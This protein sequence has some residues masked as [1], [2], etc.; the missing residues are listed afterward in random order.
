MVK[1]VAEGGAAALS[2][3]VDAGDRLLQ[4]CQNLTVGAG[5]DCSKIYVGWSPLGV[6]SSR[7]GAKN[8]FFIY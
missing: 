6:A 8:V 7:C 5:V 4:V 1:A 3:M 2:G